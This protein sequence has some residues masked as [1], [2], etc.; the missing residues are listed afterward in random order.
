M[1]YSISL[2]LQNGGRKS[3]RCPAIKI[4]NQI[5]GKS[6]I[7]RILRSAGSPRS[8][9]SADAPSDISIATSVLFSD[10]TFCLVYMSRHSYWS[11]NQG[12]SSIERDHHNHPSLTASGLARRLAYICHG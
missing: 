9:R 11:V 4:R 10:D 2:A 1:P 5:L 12:V 3:G 7:D 6:L 8:S